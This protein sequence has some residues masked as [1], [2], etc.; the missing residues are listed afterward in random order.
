GIERAEY[1]GMNM[2]RG[3]TPRRQ[4]GGQLAQERRGAAQ[5]ESAF[6][7]N[8]DPVEGG[9]SEGPSSVEIDT[10]LVIW[11]WP[12]VLAVAVAVLQFLQQST[13]LVPDRMLLAIARS[14][15][16]PNWVARLPG[17][18]GVQHRQHR[19]HANSRA[20]QHDRLAARTEREAA[21]GR[22]DLHAAA[23]L[24]ARAQ[25]GTG[26]AVFFLLDGHAI[27]PAARQVRQRVTAQHRRRA[28]LH[29]KAQNHEL[30]RQG[31][32]QGCT[33]SGLEDERKHAGTLP[34]DPR[35]P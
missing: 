13:R 32:R 15:E 10:P 18:Q 25:I 19:R 17:R 9:N 29:M 28:G 34:L 12:A 6:T 21:A 31:R 30:P 23:R 4:A 26:K 5:I 14:V 33:L 20:Q 35:H 11:S 16:P 7:R 3:H 27:M 22:A 8:A 2:I 1:L 24:Y